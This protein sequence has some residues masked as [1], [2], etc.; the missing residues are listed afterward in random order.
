MDLISQAK[1][2]AKHNY[3]N[4]LNCAESVLKSIID[5][6]IIDFPPEIV[7]LATGFGGGMGLTGNN[8]GALT[9]GVMAIG[10][11]HGRRD[12]MEKQFKDG[13]KQLYGNPGLYRLFNAFPHQFKEKFG[14]VDCKK[15][16]KN[17]TDWQDEERR[18]RCLN[19]AIET[20]GLAI[21]FIL[22]GK[23]EGY[24]QPFGINMA[25]KI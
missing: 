15:I 9:G 13:I 1:E 20:A 19:I 12:P 6:G 16:N 2:N 24:T 11:V 17:C 3:L 10:A 25:N 4:G 8:C 22:K 18:K 21:E 14:S 5:T 7:A 23:N